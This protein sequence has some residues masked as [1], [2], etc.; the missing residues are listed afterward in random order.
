M[1][2]IINFINKYKVLFLVI[3]LLAEF[4]NYFFLEKYYSVAME[5]LTASFRNGREVDTSS[6]F[7]AY[8]IAGYIRLFVLY[9]IT[10]L[11]GYCVLNPILSKY[12]KNQ[13]VCIIV[14]TILSFA[15]VFIISSIIISNIAKLLVSGKTSFGGIFRTLGN[16]LLNSIK[17]PL[18]FNVI[19]G[20]KS[21]PGETDLD[22]IIAIIMEFVYAM[23]LVET[24]LLIV[25]RR[26]FIINKEI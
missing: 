17:I 26:D 16:S 18:G 15:C 23:P 14:C 10:P 21:I 22:T 24:V 1:K 4:A 6:M 7:M 19:D 25:K 3:I 2:K 20:L 12:I 13:I 5:A 8:S 11:V 9:V